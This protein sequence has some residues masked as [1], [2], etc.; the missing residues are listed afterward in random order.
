MQIIG[1][2][3]FSCPTSFEK[4]GVEG[5]TQRSYITMQKG[6]IITRVS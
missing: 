1:L 5:E 4:K 6:E 2:T 3:K